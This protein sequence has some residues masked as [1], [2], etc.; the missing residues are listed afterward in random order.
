MSKCF[1][2]ILSVLYAAFSFAAPQQEAPKPAT[3]TAAGAQAV[4]AGGVPTWIRPETPEQRMARLG[5]PEDPGPDPDPN[6]IWGRFGHPMHISRYERRLAVYDTGDPATVRPLGMV[7][8]AYEIYQQNEKYVWV[9]VPE[10]PPPEKIAEL[11]QPQVTMNEATTNYWKGVRS[12]YV[13]L[14]PPPGKKVVRFQEASDGLP[15]AGSW[16]NALAVADMNEDGFPDL[17]APPERGG[18]STTLPTI[19]LGDGKGHWKMWEGVQWPRALDYGSVAAADLNKD[20]HMDLAF[21]VHLRGVYVFL[22]DGKGHFTSSDEGLSHKFATRKVAV[23]DVDRDGYPDLVALNEGPAAAPTTGGRLRAYLNRDKAKRWEEADIADASLQLGGDWLSVADM[24]G[25]GIPDFVAASSIQNTNQIVHLSEG[26][27]KWK[28]VFSANDD[29]LPLSSIYT[30]STAGNF[31]SKKRADAIISYARV[32]APADPQAVPEPPLTV[33]SNID[34]IT[35]TDQG[36][37]REPIVRWGS[38]LS[39]S[40]MG[41][42]DFDGDGNQD[43]IY[44]RFD[45]REARILLGDGKGGFTDVGVVGMPL[46][47]NMNYDVKVADVNGDKRPDVILMFETSGMTALSDRDGAVKVFL[48]RGAEAV[49]ATKTAAQ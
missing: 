47:Q 27:N 5:T 36:L 22:G 21:G 19:F 11:L 29:V 20:G 30:A 8:F 4:P 39:V 28:F 13:S 43:V 10:M 7:N 34:R 37:K 18:R 32:W 35:Y 9:W 3:T 15:I 45:P 12:Q 33:V 6:K 42:G 23:A 14:T 41:S 17:I 48:N 1:A 38:R 44:T 46:L 26:K 49:S 25:D 2:V 31:T 40:G 16:R 24:N